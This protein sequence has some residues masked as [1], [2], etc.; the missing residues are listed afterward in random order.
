M[1]NKLKSI[2]TKEKIKPLILNSLMIVFASFVMSVSNCFFMLPF[3]INTGG[4]SG[5]TILL[6]DFI[7]PVILNYILY[8]GLFVIGLILLGVK[9]SLSTL[10]STILIPIFSN[11]ILKTG[12]QEEFVHLILSYRALETDPVL[13]NGVIVNL[14]EVTNATPGFLLII[15]FL[16]SLLTGLGCGLCFKAGASTGGVDIITLLVTKYTGVKE[17][18]PF[19]LIDATIVATG[20]FI[21]I[22][23]ARGAYVIPSLIGI[24][25][26]CVS[27]MVLS[28]VYV[29]GQNS[30]VIDV[31]SKKYEEIAEFSIKEIDRSA[32]I[33][34]CVG[35]YSKE[36]K[37]MVRIEVSRREYVKI[38]K[39]IAEID[40]K[41]FT[42]FYNALFIG[43]EGFQRIENE[44]VDSLPRIVKNMKK[45][46][47]GK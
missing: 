25:S 47:D 3:S 16:S 13:V 20:L 22:F 12:I 2:F 45:K 11:I 38:R 37:K 8:W 28:T 14:G 5:I 15:G 39:A 21:N 9:F 41:A 34:N 44:S 17:T 23:Q 36:D 43:G 7:D 32:T 18:V 29:N 33:F 35:A 40:P 10:L 1:V 26:A 4:I 46:K 6:K 42:T 24:L 19:F 31:I 30:Y 27:S